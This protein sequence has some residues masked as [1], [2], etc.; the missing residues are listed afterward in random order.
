MICCIGKIEKASPVVRNITESVYASGTVRA[1]NQYEVCTTV[2]GTIHDILANEGA[3]VK[4]GDILVQLHHN[5]STLNT[6]NARLAS[7]YED[8]QVNQ[9][10]LN[11]ARATVALAKAKMVNDSLLLT[12]Q[13]N[14]WSQ[15]VGSRIEVEQRE[16]NFLNT[17]T[18][19]RVAKLNYADLWKQLQ[20][21]DAQAKTNWRIS[22]ALDDDYIIRSRVDGRVYKVLKEKGEFANPQQPIA[23]VGDANDFLLELTIDEY[24]IPRLQVGQRVILSLDSYRGEI[25]E[26]RIQEIEPLM[27]PTSRSFTVKASFATRPATLYP[28]LSAE[29]NIVIRA[30]E[31]ALT[32]PRTYLLSDSLV[33]LANGQKRKVT[34]GA[35]DYA[36]AEILD[37][38][39]GS[40]VIKKPSP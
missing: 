33:V 10:K 31:N 38:L 37:G 4:Q 16:V 14:L 7:E 25:F 27:D 23:I 5:V 30:K 11:A 24:D 2:A 6:Q 34:V 15:G 3:L 13:R 40:D 35:R 36:Y 32:I 26:A 28:N 9:T 21:A 17:S 22:S 18:A 39:S 20:F 29:A 8:F 12:R 1:K 19:Y